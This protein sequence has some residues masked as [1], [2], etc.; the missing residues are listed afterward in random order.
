M[1]VRMCV[2][3]CASACI[4][5]IFVLIILNYVCESRGPVVLLRLELGVLSRGCLGPGEL[6]AEY[7]RDNQ[8]DQVCN[9]S[10][11]FPKPSEPTPPPLYSSKF[12]AII[13]HGKR[14]DQLSKCLVLLYYVDAR[15]QS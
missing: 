6:V 15:L 14:K 2:Y 11:L 4:M 13:G 3:I 5:C 7:L 8:V 12:F 10:S 1:F 9:R